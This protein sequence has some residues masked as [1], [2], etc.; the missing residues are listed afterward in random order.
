M[1]YASLKIIP[2]I[3]QITFVTIRQQV[4]NITDTILT[5]SK[6]EVTS[7]E[8]D[9]EGYSKG[10]YEQ[11][12][13]FTEAEFWVKCSLP[14]ALGFKCSSVFQKQRAGSLGSN[15]ELASLA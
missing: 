12:P 10:K 9:G 4:S 14:L 1:S 15:V 5:V 13:T 3:L 2:K 6:L 11:R 8:L 7:T